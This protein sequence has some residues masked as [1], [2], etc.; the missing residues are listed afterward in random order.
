MLSTGMTGASGGSLL[1]PRSA[2]PPPLCAKVAGQLRQLRTTRHPEWCSKVFLRGRRKVYA[3]Q[4]PTGPHGK[5]E[6]RLRT[7]LRTGI[8]LLVV[9]RLL[10]MNSDHERANGIMK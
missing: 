7:M 8:R 5:A 3:T 6:W 2:A 9:P 1:A 10:Q 4:F